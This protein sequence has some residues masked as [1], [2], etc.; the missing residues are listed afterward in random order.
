MD[1]ARKEAD[2]AVTLLVARHAE[3]ERAGKALG[4]QDD[5]IR[6]GIEL[7]QCHKLFVNE[8]WCSLLG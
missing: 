7:L 1:A 6:A 2:A 5:S 3:G 4:A 8:V